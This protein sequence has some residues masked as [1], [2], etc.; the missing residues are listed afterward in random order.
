M[1]YI[2]RTCV[3]AL[4]NAILPPRYIT[5]RSKEH[6]TLNAGSKITAASG[7]MFPAYLVS[8]QALVF[9]E[10]IMLFQSIFCANCRFRKNYSGKFN[11]ASSFVQV[12]VICI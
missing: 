6:Q 1:Q 9:A 10:R 12:T 8:I 4:R 2:V 11:I 5:Y 3:N 7:E